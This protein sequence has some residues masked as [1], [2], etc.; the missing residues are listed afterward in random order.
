MA[1]E[2]DYS[3]QIFE[4]FISS[5]PRE[6]VQTIIDKDGDLLKSAVTSGGLLLLLMAEFGYSNPKDVWEDLANY[7]DLRES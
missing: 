1:E 5:E 7:R 3:Q 4:I 6:A 2:T